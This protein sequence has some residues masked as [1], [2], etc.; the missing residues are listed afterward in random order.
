MNKSDYDKARSTQLPWLEKYRPNT[1]C[2]VML[3]DELDSKINKF[4]EEKNIPNM[5]FTGPPGSGKTSTIRC[6]AKALYGKYI[7]YMVLE[8]NVSDDRGMKNM[9]DKIIAF[10]KARVVMKN[11]DKQKYANYKLIILDEADNMVDRSQPQIN[12]IMKQYEQRARFAFTCNSSANIIEGI[13]SRCLILRYMR[14]KSNLIIK[15]LKYIAEKENIKYNEKALTYLANI[16]RGDMRAAINILQLVH[17]NR[18]SIQID[19]IDQLCDLPHHIALNKMIMA[20]IDKKLDL[21]F[22]I[23]IELKNNGYTGSDIMLGLMSTLKSDLCNNISEKIKVAIF[24]Q[25]CITTY[26]ISKGIDT[27]LQLYSCIID[28]F[29]AISVI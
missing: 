10:C 26:N 28:I 6:I 9:Q 19:Y 4:I 17:T 27:Q 20:I 29:N 7:D 14:L 2:G 13:Q 23:A 22:N 25:V 15:K 16:S 3:P 8:L 24:E 5:I 12:E 11:D 21:A 1:I 18:E